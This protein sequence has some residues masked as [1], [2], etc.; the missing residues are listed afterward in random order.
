MP[1]VEDCYP[2]LKVA[3]FRRR[4]RAEE[5]LRL[6]GQGYACCLSSQLSGDHGIRR[7]VLPVGRGIPLLSPCVWFP[8]ELLPGNWATEDVRVLSSTGGPA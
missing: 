6:R 2:A 4:A 7:R 5:G 8:L 3:M 1:L